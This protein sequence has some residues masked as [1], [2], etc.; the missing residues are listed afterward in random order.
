MHQ[1]NVQIVAREAFWRSLAESGVNISAVPKDQMDALV[2][3][4]SHSVFAVLDA[5]EDDG[6]TPV[7]APA[8]NAAAATEDYDE[9]KLLWRGRPYLTIGVRYELTSERLRIIRGLFGTN[10]EE[11]ELVRIRDTKVKQHVGERMLNVG[12]ITIHSN[13][14]STP[15]FVLDNVQD[16]IEVREMIRAAT[17]DEKE[18]RGLHYREEM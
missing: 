1:D 14:P 10:L 3:A 17:M 12:D 11:I 4:I 9:E 13:D 5:V 7:A 15:E 6:H 8:P 16:P 18:R 2:D